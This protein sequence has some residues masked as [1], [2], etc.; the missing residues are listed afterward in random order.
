MFQNFHRAHGV[1][2]ISG[3]ISASLYYIEQLPPVQRKHIR[4]ATKLPNY[5][6]DIKTSEGHNPWNIHVL[7]NSRL[8]FPRPSFHAKTT[9]PLPHTVIRQITPWR[10]IPRVPKTTGQPKYVF[11][12]HCA[13]PIANKPRHTPPLHPSCT[14]R[15]SPENSSPLWTPSQQTRS[16]MSVAAMENSQQT[17]SLPSTPSWALT[18][19]RPWSSLPTKTTQALRLPSVS[20]IVGTWKKKR[21]LWMDHG[22]K[23]M[24]LIIIHGV[25]WMNSV[26][27]SR[28]N[29]QRSPPLDLTRCVDA[30]VDTA[31]NLR[32][33]EA[34]WY[35]CVWDG[36]T[37]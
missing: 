12:W 7:I 18:R 2:Y 30:H 32:L 37:W 9:S 31:R 24:P 14:P 28:Q 6:Q 35:I 10:P 23:C 11:P 29:L 26:S 34:G 21:P 3:P 22:I 36:R 33:S 17:S 13:R 8:C 19:L 5:K 25:R 15:N 20:W 1:K 27:N 16:S 4:E